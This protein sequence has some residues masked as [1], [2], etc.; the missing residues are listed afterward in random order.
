MDPLY[1]QSAN[2]IFTLIV[3]YDKKSTTTNARIV[4]KK[5]RFSAS[6][7]ASDVARVRGSRSNGVRVASVRRRRVASVR[8]RRVG[9][10]L[11]NK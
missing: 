7:V 10:V 1:K 11:G 8:R 5:E 2:T 9:E 6:G 4:E 3:Y